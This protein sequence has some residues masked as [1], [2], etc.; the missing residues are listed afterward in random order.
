MGKRKKESERG[1]EGVGGSEEGTRGGGGAGREG[2]ERRWLRGGRVGGRWERQRE[3]GGR[4][5]ERE[6]GPAHLF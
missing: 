6:G 3:V 2:E 5:R 1:L 4:E